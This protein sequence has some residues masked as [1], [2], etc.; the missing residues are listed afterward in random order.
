MA[1]V[2]AA[3]T[4]RRRNDLVRR[5]NGAGGASEVFAEASTSLRHLVPF[6]AAAWVSTDPATGLPTGPTRLDNVEGITA[7]Q[8]SE[9]W[10]YEFAVED[11]N[12]LSD[13]TVAE[14]PVAT[15]RAIANDPRNSI[16]YRRFLEPLGFDDELRAV[17]RVGDAPWGGIILWRRHGRPAFNPKETELVATLTEPIGEAL[18]VR[19]RPAEALGGL[20]RRDR[21]GH[22]DLRPG[23]RA[24]LGQR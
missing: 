15:L 12:K 14:R 18:R 5:V 9:H 17:L 19:A 13:L 11:I 16:R 10:R 3:E 22:D 8:C 24:D 2:T 6:D 1:A 21:P 4:R 23:R 20:A 7:S